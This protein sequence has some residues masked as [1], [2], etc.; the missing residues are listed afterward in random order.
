[1]MQNQTFR[2][3]AFVLFTLAAIMAQGNV[4]AAPQ[5][6]ERLLMDGGWKFHLGDPGG[7]AAKPETTQLQWRFKLLARGEETSEAPA[8]VDFQ[9]D[10]GWKDAGVSQDVFNG[11]RGF[12]WY[13]ATLPNPPAGIRILHF[14]GV[15]DNATVYVNGK[16]LLHH[17]GYDEPFDVPLKEVW[18][19]G[20]PN[21]IAVLVEN[22]AGAGSIG[23]SGF[24]EREAGVDDT[25]ARPGFQDKDWRNVH[26]PHDFVVERTFTPT[27]DA[28][29]GSLPTGIGWYRKTFALPASDRGRALWVDFDGIY[30]NATI[31]INGKLLG[32]HKSGYIGAHYD[33]SELVNYGG[34]NT[35]AVRADARA[36][37]GWWY[38]G[39]G[40]YRHV[41]LNK[42][43]PLHVATNGVFVAPEVATDGSANLRIKVTLANRARIP[44]SDWLDA[45]VI[46]PGGKLIARYSTHPDV[47]GNSNL[48]VGTTLKVEN[49]KLWSLEVPTLYKMVAHLRRGDKY[50]DEVTT[51]FG[52]RTIKFDA[53]KGFF[54]NGKPVKIQ[55]TCNHQDFAGV[56]IA[57]PDSL[58]EWRIK[59]LKEMG[60]NAYRMSHNPPAPELL[61]A[62]DRLGMLVMDENRH[63]GD[64]YRAQNAARHAG[65]RS[66]RPE[67]HGP[68]RPQPSEHHHVVDVQRGGLAGQRRKGARIFAAMKEVDRSSSTRRGPIT[69]RD[70]RRLGQ[71][72]LRSWRTCRASTTAP[73][74][75]DGFHQQF[76]DMPLF[77]SETASAVS[78]RG[79]YVNDPQKGYVSA[80]DVNAPPWAQTAEVAWKAIANARLHGR[81]LRL[82]RLRLQGR[83]DAVWLAVHQ[84]ALRH[85][86]QV[87]L[88]QGHLL[89][90]LSPGGAT[91]PSSTS[92]RTGTGRAR[93]ASRSTSGSTATPTGSSCS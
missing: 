6:R 59:K 10:T 47:E 71:R 52:I 63:L 11:R 87:R 26:L 22:T 62:C 16:K 73:A 57:M 72:H 60:C 84:L 42:A 70:E 3:F 43:M 36:Q 40:I 69:V 20:G 77:G 25:Y 29:H 64:T 5:G 88:P 68:A 8:A 44:L 38:E 85:H 33:I 82:D 83:A 51:N 78:T 56:G 1:M 75:Y 18:K 9:M 2:T 12:A 34:T 66:V 54:L 31:W 80:Y 91:S 53:E 17:E 41:W 50:V 74:R 32:N 67:R 93:R 45:D 27:A 46:D 28:S 90:L 4:L 15:D 48:E 30:R 21:V 49:P 61:D 39:G 13:R 19:E 92:C 65:T 79:E 35:L 7:G 76:P 14:E 55:G 86:G 37:E 89:L 58:L 23:A 81:R 24:Q